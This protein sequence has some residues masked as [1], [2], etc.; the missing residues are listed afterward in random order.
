[1]LDGAAVITYNGLK[2]EWLPSIDY[3]Q[4]NF[5]MVQLPPTFASIPRQKLLFNHASPIE[6]LERLSA[7][8]SKQESSE[9]SPTY[10]VKHE[11][12]NSG[13]AYGGN[14]VRKLEY[15]IADAINGGYDTIVTTGGVQSNHMRQTSAVAAKCGLKVRLCVLH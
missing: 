4:V 8:L 13:L 10:W 3:L 12:C 7:Y 14:K 2:T 5:S 9:Q 6:P 1:M 11:D 15:V